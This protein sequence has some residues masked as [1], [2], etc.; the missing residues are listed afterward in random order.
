MQAGTAVPVEE[1]AI[2]VIV[3]YP[4]I[5]KNIALDVISFVQSLACVKRTNTHV[6]SN[7]GCDLFGAFFVIESPNI[8]A[9]L[10]F[11]NL[12]SKL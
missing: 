7:V 5:E 10:F 3:L 12:Q 4:T 9:P 2:S 1:N 8:L 6:K 11:L